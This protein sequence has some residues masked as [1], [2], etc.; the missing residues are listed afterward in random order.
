MVF[1]KVI[2]A[3]LACAAGSAMAASSAFG[4][5]QTIVGIDD[6][7][8]AAS[9]TMDQGDRPTFQNTGTGSHDVTAKTN[10]PDGKFLFSSPTIGNGSTVVEGT[11]YLT[12]GSY[13]F[14]CTVHPLTMTANLQVSALGAPVARPKVD[15]LLANGKLE[16]IAKKGKVQA[17]VKALTKSDGIALELALGKSVIATQKAFNL[18]AGQQR[19]VT[20]KLNKAGKSK[21][22]KAGSAK[23]KLT[24]EVPFGAPDSAKKTYK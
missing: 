20:L 22:A 3:T 8:V 9:Y 23:L 4:V 19:K 10:G 6:S 1:L 2:A 7:Y 15:V 17:T 12:T 13:A 21:L 16:K 14:F 5:A 18:A 24:G 11:Q